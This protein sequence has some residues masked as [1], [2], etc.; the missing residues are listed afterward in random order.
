MDAETNEAVLP[1]DLLRPENGVRMGWPCI[2]RGRQQPGCVREHASGCLRM[3]G[4]S[5]QREIHPVLGGTGVRFA[6]SRPAW[7]RYWSRPFDNQENS[8]NS[9]DHPI[10]RNRIRDMMLSQ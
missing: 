10:D 8:P 2:R 7:Q 5:V 6:H 3:T 4:F 1:E 9:G